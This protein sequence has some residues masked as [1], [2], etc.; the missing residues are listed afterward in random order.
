MKKRIE[1]HCHTKMSQMKGLCEPKELIEK[2]DKFGISGIAITDTDSVQ[3][4]PKTIREIEWAGKR[5]LYENEKAPIVNVFYGV[6]VHLMGCLLI[7]LKGDEVKETAEYKT[8][9]I[10]KNREGITAINKLLS[11][12]FMDCYEGVRTI[13]K[14]QL[15]KYRENLIIGSCADG[16]EVMKA[17][18]MDLPIDD[19]KKVMA[20]YDFIEVLPAS[21][22]YRP[23]E[24]SR[25]EKSNID[26][27]AIVSAIVSIAKECG[28]PVIASS[29]VYYI[30]SSDKEAFDVLRFTSKDID[31]CKTEEDH[32]LMTGE[33]LMKEFSFLGEKDGK[34]IVYDNPLKIVEGIGTL[35]IENTEKKYPVVP[36]AY[37][38]LKEICE[39]SIR[40]IYCSGIPEEVSEQL[41]RE[42]DNI[43]KNGFESIYY[44]A[45]TL[46][47]KSN[48]AG[49]LVGSRGTA[50]ASLI[51]YLLGITEMNPMSPHYYCKKCGYS[52]FKL[53]DVMHFHPGD[54]GL[55][56]P[57]KKCPQC[58]CELTKDGFDIPVET[59]VGLDF[60]KEPD[61]DLNFASEY[62]SIAQEELGK[63]GG[64]D[65]VYHAGT[66]GCLAEQTAESLVQDYIEK[67]NCLTE[68]SVEEARDR[69]TGVKRTEGFHPG[70]M[71]IVPEGENINLVTPVSSK[72]DDLPDKTQIASFD[73]DSTFLKFDVLGHKVPSMLKALKE[74]TGVDPLS[75]PLED[76]K[77]MSLFTEV[78]ELGI[79]PEQ[80]GGIDMGT[81]GIP[82]LGGSPWVRNVY[83][84]VNPKSFSDL[85]RIEGFIHG[86]DV[87]D[88][89]AEELI[90]MGKKPYELIANRDD[91]MSYLISK[92]MEPDKAFMMMENT[93][94]GKVSRLEPT[95][96]LILNMKKYGI[97]KWYIESCKK[98]KYLFPK[99]H[100]VGYLIN[101]WRLLYYKLYYPK[102]FYHRWLEYLAEYV[103]SYFVRKGYAYAKK[104]LEE[105]RAESLTGTFEWIHRHIE[106][107]HVVLEMHARGV[108]RPQWW[109]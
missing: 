66:I 56:L 61:F 80:I 88:G 29:D 17:I 60:S 39:E 55:D 38:K 9:I 35:Q 75:I 98:I 5:A 10:A 24:F 52:D 102:Y 97:P 15:E 26:M 92:G 43:H 32:H 100:T 37:D 89:N 4:Y 109:K 78:S 30:E 33:E 20:F 74:D 90:N 96:E 65:A 69:I 79:K 104:E 83:K 76:P 47:R 67:G 107:V 108:T 72:D 8:T 12:S 2:A 82:E 50:G 53:K 36:G 21:N 68:L 73:I 84:T 101:E 77:M 16:G 40:K 93:R 27:M 1:L 86:T 99:A 3:A 46:V 105:L 62:Q 64:I 48:E 94:K 71:I 103:D 87:W 25:D 23:L 14:E 22:M 6:E 59:F 13:H 19:I 91:I 106:E 54:V 85:I 44:I 81:L 7:T 70:K 42:L 45:H 18:N 63:I 58:G 11:D 28:V 49:Y 51:A 95:D 34:A 31:N 57:D 41:K